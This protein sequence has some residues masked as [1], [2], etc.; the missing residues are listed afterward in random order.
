MFKISASEFCNMSTCR[1]I[2][3][4]ILDEYV[5]IVT[6]GVLYGVCYVVTWSSF[7]VTQRHKASGGK[8]TFH[9]C[10]HITYEVRM[11]VEG[12]GRFAK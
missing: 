4:C 9:H 11:V 10:H 8:W 6:E 3:A 12:Q 7:G 1:Q 2:R 5:T